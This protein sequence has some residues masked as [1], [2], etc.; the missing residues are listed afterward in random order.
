MESG[1]SGSALGKPAIEFRSSSPTTALPVQ[2]P[3][4]I[5][6]PFYTTKPVGKGTGLG[7]S[8]CY[9]I[10]KEHG[11]EIQVRNSPRGVTFTVTLPLISATAPAVPPQQ[12][13]FGRRGHGKQNSSRGKRRSRASSGAGGSGE[14][15]SFVRT[16]RSAGEAME[17]L[18]RNRSMPR[19]WT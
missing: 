18:R 14:K 19:S 4:R 2:N 1:K 3:H 6:D 15:G 10:V 11:G 17:I 12:T 7:L 5:F 8:I 13:S 9:G 16:A